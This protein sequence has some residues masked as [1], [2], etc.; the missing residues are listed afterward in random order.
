MYEENAYPLECYQELESMCD[1][2][3]VMLVQNAADGQL[4]VK[5][6][7][8]TFAPELYRQLREE[9]VPGTPVIYDIYPDGEP[10]AAGAASL[11]IIEEYIPGRTLAQVLREEGSFS[12]ADTITIGMALCD[13]LRELHSR[14]PAII[15]RDIKPGNIMRQPDGKIVLLDFSAAKPQ[16]LWE[17]RDTVLIGTAGFAAPEQYGFSASTAQTDLYSM[18]VLLNTLR[19]GALP[20]E[21]RA[22]GQLRRVIDRCLKLNPEDRFIDAR[23]L[24]SALKRV[25]RK[26]VEWLPP[27]FRSLRWYRM[28]PAICFYAF[29]LLIGL[30][31]SMDVLLRQAPPV[32]VPIYLLGALSPVLFYCNYLDVQRFFPF[33]RSNSRGLRLLGMLLFPLCLLAFLLT[34]LFLTEMI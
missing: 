15:H 23:E 30:G 19:T 17:S 32:T 10:D 31:L 33:M 18:G 9:P 26:R 20:W 14:R 7:V 4:Y 1:K 22:G 8:R 34:A 27:G 12:E 3:H 25:S 5:K 11:V 6:R 24:H 16:N 28:I 2:G 21:Q 13:I 29:V